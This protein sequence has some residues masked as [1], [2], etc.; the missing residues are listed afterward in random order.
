MYGNRVFDI[1]GWVHP[2][3]NYILAEVVGREV[4]RFL[5]GAYSL[6]TVET[7]THTHSI[8]ALNLLNS[9]YIG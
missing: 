8:Y 1:T 9:F 3:G 7:L 6:E 5:H 2:G 4:S